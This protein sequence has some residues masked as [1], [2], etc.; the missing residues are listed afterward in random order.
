MIGMAI[1]VLAKVDFKAAVA[2]NI[3]YCFDWRKCSIIAVI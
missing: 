2:S 3:T 1:Y